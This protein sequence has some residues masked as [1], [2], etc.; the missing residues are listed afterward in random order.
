MVALVT[1]RRR[2][3]RERAAY[4][5]RRMRELGVSVRF[6]APRPAVT[7]GAADA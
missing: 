6:G 4:C 5:R 7:K 2:G 3:D 1:A